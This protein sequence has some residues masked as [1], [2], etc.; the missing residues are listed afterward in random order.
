MIDPVKDWDARRYDD[1][2]SF[3]TSYGAAVLD[4]LAARPG[5]RVLDLGCGTG[6]HAAQ[7]A[8][9]GVVAVGLDADAAMLEVARAEHPEVTFVEGDA[10]S[11]DVRQLQEAAG[12]AYDAVFSNAAMHWL[13]RQDDVVAGVRG[14]LRPG[15]RFVVEMGGFGNVAAVTEA[16]RAAR[17]AVG[18][19]AEV[20]APWTFPTPGQQATRLEA[21]GFCVELVQLFARP[22][23]LAAGDT[24]AAWAAMMGAGLV[25]DVPAAR[26]AE[27]DGA[28]DA[29]AAELGLARR[30]DGAPGWWADYVRLRF[31][32]RLPT[33]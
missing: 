3:V 4:L 14:V 9:A 33:A 1:R 12:G 15:G 30:H 27:F 24:P 2:F 13:P 7:L 20:P 5:E 28:L 31:V 11:L 23:P 21:H 6:H 18:L 8:A 19:D 16:I 29:R 32:A 25:A 10:Q 17:A 22:T 26:R